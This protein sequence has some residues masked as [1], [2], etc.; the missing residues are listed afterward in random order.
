M[1]ALGIQ[2]RQPEWAD[3]VAASFA[4]IIIITLIAVAESCGLIG[5][6]M[7]QHM[8]TACAAL[9]ILQSHGVDPVL[10]GWRGI[11]LYLALTLLLE[12]LVVVIAAA[13]GAT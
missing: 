4:G 11:A 2:I 10:N 5:S 9:L 13:S 12:T 1:Q 3:I 8:G 7:A 6:L